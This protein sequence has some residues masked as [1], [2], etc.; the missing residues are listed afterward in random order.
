MR[1]KKELLDYAFITIGTLLTAIAIVLF[2]QPLNIVAGGV[3]GLAIAMKAL[4]GFDLSLQVLVYNI[5]LFILGFKLLGLGFG[6][7]SIYSSILLS[8]LIWILEHIFHLNNVLLNLD[9]SFNVDL[10]L[11]A[12]I[13]GAVL[14]GLGLGI[15]MWRG[16]TTGGTD[17]IAMILNK[18]LHV[19][20][21]TG[22]MVTDAVVTMM[23][24]FINPILPMYGLIAIFVTG[25]TID[26]VV[27]GLSSTRTVLIISDEYDKIKDRIYT[28]LE[29]GV[30]Y[31]KG[32]GSYTGKEKNIIMVTVARNEIG[33]LKSTV[34][35]IDE[36]SFTIILPNLEAIG[37]GFKKFS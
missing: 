37:Y 21:G 22:L 2:L 35:H 8:A 15:V 25:K 28:D 5:I 32:V 11:M 6:V 16:A 34:K 23:A 17:I 3:S 36:N 30:T 33:E 31:L 18:Y 29:R 13:Y 19:S 14:A 10:T 27:D 20:V 7:K 26:A 1:F 12:S 4:F 9:N 24:F